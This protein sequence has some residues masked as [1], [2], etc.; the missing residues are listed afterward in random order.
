MLESHR[1]TQQ[2]FIVIGSFAGNLAQAWKSRDVCSS[3]AV[4][5]ATLVTLGKGVHE[6]FPSLQTLIPGAVGPEILFHSI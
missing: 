6:L 2:L 4:S 5:L 3:S 1:W